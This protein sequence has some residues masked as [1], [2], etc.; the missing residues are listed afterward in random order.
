[1]GQTLQLLRQLLLQINR[2][3]VDFVRNSRG[4]RF[5]KLI[6][7]IALVVGFGFITVFYFGDLRGFQFS[8]S[9]LTIFFSPSRKFW[10][11]EV[12]NFVFP[13][14]NPYQF[15]GHPLF[16][17]LQAGVLYPFS[18]LYLFLP[19][20][21]AFNLNIEIHFVL[22]G[23]FTYLLLRGMKASRG[24]S[25]IAGLGFMLSGYLISVH[26]FISTLFSVAWVPLFFL[27]F[28]AAIQKN[29][30]GYALLSGFVGTLMF[31]GGGGE[32]C[33][34][35][36]AVAFFLTLVPDLAL[37]ESIRPGLKRR[38]FLFASFCLVFLGL[39]AVQLIPLMELSALSVR[40]QG[41]SYFEA[42]N[43]SLHP[44][45]LIEFFIPDQFGLA[46]DQNQYWMYQNWLRTIYMGGIPFLLSCFY[47]NKYSSRRLGL[48]FLFVLSIGLAMG[49]NTLFHHFLYD[50]IPFFN[51]LRYPV[52]FIFL[53]ILVLCITA[54][55]GFDRFRQELLNSQKS[56]A[57]W[58]VLALAFC[59]MLVFGILNYFDNEFTTYFKGIGWDYP[60]YNEIAAN[61]FNV[62]RLLAFTSLFCLLLYLYA[63]QEGKQYILTII[64]T[65]FTLDLF[66]ANYGNYRKD[67][68]E[69]INKVSEN[70]RF[71]LSDPD[72]F[73]VYTAPHTIK[74]S[75]G[76]RSQ[77]WGIEISKEKLVPGLHVNKDIF[78]A[79]GTGVTKQQRWK[80]I[81]K[82]ISTGSSPDRTDLLNIMNVKYIISIPKIVSK[83]FKLVHISYPIPL[84]ENKKMGA[85]ESLS[86]KIYEN[87]NILPRV[88][89]VP[90]CKIIRKEREY[91]NIFQNKLFDPQV[92]VLLGKN[93]KGFDCEAKNITKLIVRGTVEITSYKSNTVDLTVN[94]KNRQ[95]LFLSDSYYPGWKAYVDGEET[96]I[97]R[98]NYLFRAIVVTPG[99]HK[100][101]F[102]YDPLSFKLG[103]AI[104]M[105]TI[106][107]CGIYFFRRKNGEK[108][109]DLST[110]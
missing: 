98:A 23:W 24:A 26:S 18:V 6:G 93:P 67:S 36:F 2:I 73:R 22:S 83:N 91:K 79:M 14:W 96:E 88:F 99:E 25:L 17:T 20:H 37:T 52:K 103:L 34:F 61:L 38:L 30:T 19:F 58:V 43:W 56:S 15:N 64:I 100:V 16:A 9:D 21:S 89:L 28:L 75:I 69:R 82:L 85:E 57:K 86:I 11:E 71:I 65:L 49:T 44:K 39:S 87:K 41:L 95:L 13:L 55:L 29:R 31:L 54:G 5:N 35:T 46:H 94:S 60:K 101:R 3:L 110:Y 32:V 84:S 97:L 27:I 106:L 90:A 62:K 70:A 12:K 42:S 10:L 4:P 59:L 1:M 68:V 74:Y 72:F 81:F 40:A 48:L 107:L 104:S 105:A 63:R 102:E 80:N 92:V 109:T 108:S 7:S 77:E 51:K 53:G 76:P 33:Y 8:A 78:Y 66:F 47:F 50:H 45:G